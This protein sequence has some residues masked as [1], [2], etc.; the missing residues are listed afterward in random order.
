M[1]ALITTITEAFTSGAGS[2]TGIIGTVVTISMPILMGMM[3]VKF[4]I[5]SFRQVI[6]G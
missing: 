4:G 2:M 5:K 1:E 3:V 6:G